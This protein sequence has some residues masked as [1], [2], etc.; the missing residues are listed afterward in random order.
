MVSRIQFE[1]A[2]EAESTKPGKI[3]AIGALLSR[4]TGNEVTIVA[5]SAIEVQTRGQTVSNDIDIVT[6]SGPAERAVGSWGFFRSGRLWRR[7]DWNIDLDLLGTSFHGSR[8]RRRFIQTRYGPVYVTG[9]EDLIA[10]RL[11][12]L[13]HRDPAKGFGGGSAWRN[14]L[15]QH[16]QIL[17]AEY[18]GK[19]DEEYLASLAKRD[20]I[21]DILATFR[22]RARS[23]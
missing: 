14:E 5:G 22:R 18:D 6:E 23:E 1:R 12:E 10:Y 21:V 3:L 4:A 9:A 2:V 11:S 13:K 17:L 8:S 20:D 16:V 7:D 19:L 15:V